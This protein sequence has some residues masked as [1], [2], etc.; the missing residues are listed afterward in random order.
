MP[1][2]FQRS[3]NT[4][5]LLGSGNPSKQRALRWLLEGLPLAPKTPSQLGLDFTPDEL[6]DTHQDIANAKALDWSRSGSMLAIASDGGLVLPA[7]GDAWESR[8]THRFAGPEVTNAQRLERLMD[9][10]KSFQGEER[11]ATWVEAVAVADQGNLLTSWEL[12]GATGLIADRPTTVPDSDGFWAFSVWYFPDLGKTYD[13]LSQE[14]REGLDDHWAQL[15]TKVQE[16]F[17]RNWGPGR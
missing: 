15:R 14:Q 17:G 10:M 6:G 13:Q 1:A 12:K 5:I 16:F 3:K 2:N 9:L 7:L 4:P 8:Y 11:Q